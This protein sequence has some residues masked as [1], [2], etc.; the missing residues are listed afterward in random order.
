MFAL[1]SAPMTWRQYRIVAIAS[2]GQMVGTALATAVGVIIPML[3]ILASPSLSAM[4]QGLL[5]AADLIGIMIGAVVFGNLTE[6]YGYILFFRLCP[7]LLTAAAVV[8]ALCPNTWVLA[9]ALLVMGFGIGGEYSLDSDYISELL[10]K[11]YRALMT[12]IA[13]ASS[14]VGSIIAAA[15]CW[16][17][18]A[19]CPRADMWPQMMWIVAAIG[20]VMLVS[21]I[22]FWESP[23][24]LLMQGRVAAAQRMVHEFL[25]PNVDISDAVVAKY[26]AA[27]SD[28][29]ASDKSANLSTAEFLKT[30]WR[31][32]VL[33]GV[34]WACEGLGVYGFGVFLPILIMALGLADNGAPAGSIWHVT[35]SVRLTLLISIIMLPGFI[36]GLWLIHRRVSVT[37]I[38]TVGFA[39]CAVSLTVLAVAYWG[40]WPKWISITAF[41]AFELFLNMGPHLVT[42]ILPPK[43]Y[44]IPTRSLGSGIA[45]SIGKTGAV[46]GVLLIPLVLNAYGTMAVL[47]L[48]ACVMA[49]GAAITFAFRRYATQNQQPPAS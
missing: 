43:S 44:S 18:L 1:I 22:R 32:V 41:M 13:K 11:S 36:L 21:R 47:L 17:L 6:R 42:Y 14:S 34:P 35:E 2:L 7:A 45:A 37:R 27:R 48:S 23:K 15:V 25:G 30:N 28:D 19:V 8:A 46:G 12:G 38:Q 4:E 24:W 16:A 39:L 3:N 9:I 10:P 40:H 29:S 26:T 20:A 31:R 5:G 33:T 49:A